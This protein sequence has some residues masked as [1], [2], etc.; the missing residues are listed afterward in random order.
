VHVVAPLEPAAGWDKVKEFSK[1][2]AEALVRLAPD[3]YVAYMSKAR[4]KGKIFVDYL[5]NGRGATAICPYSTR[6][7]QAASVS[8]PIHWDE[9]GPDLRPD[10]FTVGNMPERLARLG[11]DPWEGIDRSRQ[12][13]TAAMLERLV[14]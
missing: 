7:R 6:A 12:S 10:R 8:A 14:K 4:R 2:I 5:R 3:R 1:K 13:I 9:L 11:R